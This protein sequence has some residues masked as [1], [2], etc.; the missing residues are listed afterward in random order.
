VQTVLL[1]EPDVHL[2]SGMVEALDEAGFTCVVAT[3]AAQAQRTL[4][5]IAPV[6]TVVDLP[7]SSASDL[8]RWKA[9]TAGIAHI[10]VVLVTR[11]ST[12][13]VLDGVLGLLRKPFDARQLLDVV[14]QTR[15]AHGRGVRRRTRT[16]R[17]RRRGRRP[18]RNRRNP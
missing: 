14:D 4:N 8:L 18:S 15:F 6:L 12:P 5:E 7:E 3:N 16:V 17:L 2:A 13:S 10:P 11:G 9:A 1:V